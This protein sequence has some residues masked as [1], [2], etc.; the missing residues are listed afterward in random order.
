VEAAA[1]VSPQWSLW[2]E[3]VCTVGSSAKHRRVPFPS[4]RSRS[5]TRTGSA[6]PRPAQPPDR[7]R[8]VVED[9]EAEPAVGHRV[10]E[11]AA[12]VHGDPA[13]PH[14]E[15]GGLDGA[16][17]HQPL[18]VEDASASEGGHLHAEDPGERLRLLHGL[19]V[20]GRVHPEEVLQGG[21]AGLERSSGPRSPASSSAPTTFSPRRG[22]MGTPK[23]PRW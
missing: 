15:P 2:I 16:A 12:E 7:D 21:G 4:C 14:R 17:R 11:A 5:T 22:S 13:R 1:S 19:Q 8:D 20:L 3:K 9:A 18:L 10:V 23:T 6:N